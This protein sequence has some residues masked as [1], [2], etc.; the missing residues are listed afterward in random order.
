MYDAKEIHRKYL[1]RNPPSDQGML[2][3]DIYRSLASPASSLLPPVS[4][5]RNGEPQ[6][7]ISRLGIR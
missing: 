7:L 2:L 3:F 4:S 6:T 1:R 5:S